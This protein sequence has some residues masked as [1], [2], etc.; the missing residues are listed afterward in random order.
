MAIDFPGST[1]IIAPGGSQNGHVPQTER[2]EAEAARAYI[3]ALT[4]GVR[5]QEKP[6][7]ARWQR[8][9][10]LL[11]QNFEASGGDIAAMQRTVN[12]FALSPGGA[13][14]AALLAGTGLAERRIRFL[15]DEAFENRPPRAW[16]IP[17]ILPQSGIAMVYGP[18]SSGKSFLVMAWSLC[19]ARGLP[20][21]NHKL[22]QGPVAYIAAE[23][24]SG[25]KARMHAWKRYQGLLGNS[26]VRWFDQTLM[27]QDKKQMDELI[28]ALKEDFPIPPVLVVI[29]T[30]SRCSGGAEENSNTDMAKVVSSA[31]LLQQTFGCTVLLVHHVG[32]DAQKGPRGASA[33]TGNMETVM[34]VVPTDEGCRLICTKQK[35][36]PR[37]PPISLEL[38]PVSWGASEEESSAILVEGHEEATMNMT[39]SETVMF[40][41]LMGKRLTYSEWARAGVE[42]GLAERTAKDAIGKLKNME[43]VSQTGKLYHISD[44]YVTAISAGQGV[45]TGESDEAD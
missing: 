11:E 44:N 41:T 25:L 28:A 20:W 40:A 12:S 31:D 15:D 22:V 13:D 30:L 21:L 35:D 8:W 19:I 23:G 34:E 16:L 37:F 14:L 43:R 29:D 38:K 33:L 2:A 26:G 6:Q 9:L 1:A 5:P 42:A 32:K 18:P 24:S 27:L 45:V 3:A 17:G 36:A 39:N 10:D 4:R 7:A